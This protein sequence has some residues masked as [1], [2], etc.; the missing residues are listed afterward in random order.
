M[1][2]P[3]DTLQ[4]PARDSA[5]CKICVWPRGKSAAL[6][7]DIS[8]HTRENISLH[9]RE[10]YF[11]M[12]QRKY[13]SFAAREIYSCVFGVFEIQSIILLEFVMSSF[14]L[15]IK[16]CCLLK[17]CVKKVCSLRLANAI[18]AC[19]GSWFRQ[20]P[21]NPP[22]TQLWLSHSFLATFVARTESG[23]YLS[24]QEPPSIYQSKSCPPNLFCSPL[25]PEINVYNYTCPEREF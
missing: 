10:I 5:Q 2:P 7:S 9:T 12:Y 6:V 18:K 24:R 25:D 21:S 17:V 8:L 13:I 22:L 20:Q 1:W 15:E 19:S 11:S 14:Q 23:I 3:W 16:M 4:H